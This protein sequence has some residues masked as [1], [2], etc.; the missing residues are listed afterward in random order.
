MIPKSE[1]EA[2]KEISRT[3]AS[4]SELQAICYKV[5]KIV[6]QVLSVDRGSLFILSTDSLGN[7]KLV[8]QLFDIRAC[9]GKEKIE[10]VEVPEMVDGN[11]NNHHNN[12]NLLQLPSESINQKTSRSQSTIEISTP[13]KG[14]KRQKRADSIVVDNAQQTQ[15]K[16]LEVPVDNKSVLG[17]VALSWGCF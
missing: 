9:S 6:C 2:F 10:E 14:V 17:Q 4:Q 3:V 11:N 5:L 1:Y 12:K 13:L 7:K 15:I 8:S 16:S